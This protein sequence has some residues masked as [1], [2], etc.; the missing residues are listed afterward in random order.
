VERYA[1]FLRKLPVSL[2]NSIYKV[3]VSIKILTL[4]IVELYTKSIN[5]RPDH[6]LLIVT[7]YHIRGDW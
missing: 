5:F 4:S 3:Y 2:P 6:V 1:V 7:R